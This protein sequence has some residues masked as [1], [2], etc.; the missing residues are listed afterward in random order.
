MLQSCVSTRDD[1]VFE[2]SDP[3]LWPFCAPWE[4]C[5]VPSAGMVAR[6][7]EKTGFVVKCQHR[8]T[9]FRFDADSETSILRS[10]GAGEQI[11]RLGAPLFMVLEKNRP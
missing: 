8:L 7:F 2:L 6:V 11:G 1:P 9:D 4:F 10:G 3:E 5:L